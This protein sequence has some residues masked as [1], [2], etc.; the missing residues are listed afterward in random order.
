MTTENDL[1]N[2]S[3]EIFTLTKFQFYYLENIILR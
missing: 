3:L 1:W 2:K